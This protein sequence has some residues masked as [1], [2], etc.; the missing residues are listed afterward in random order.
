MQIKRFEAQSMTAALKMIKREFGPEAVILSAR[1]LKQE[2]GIF[3]FV[4]RPKVEVT[5]ATDRPPVVAPGAN[6]IERAYGFDQVKADEIH[7]KLPEKK[8]TS[9]GRVW[10]KSSASKYEICEVDIEE[11]V[12][13]KHAKELFQIHQQM[14]SQGIEESIVSDLLGEVNR[15]GVSKEFMESRAIRECLINVLERM[16]VSTEPIGVETGRQAIA[17]FVG[18]A[19]V[20]KTTTIA[21]IA[22]IHAVH[23]GRQVALITLDDYRI[24]AVEQ[25]KVYAKIIGIPAITASNNQ[26]L[27]RALRKLADYDLI[28]I[29]TAGMTKNDTFKINELK[30]CLDRISNLDTHLLL[31]AAIKEKDLVNTIERF[32]TIPINKLL[33][34]K[35]D[36]TGTCGVILNQVIQTKL[37]VSYFTN[38]QGVPEDIT[39]PNLNSLV[40]LILGDQKENKPWRA[41]QQAV[42]NMESEGGARQPHAEAPFVANRNTDVFHT[43]DCKWAKKIMEKNMIVFESV[44]HAFEKGYDPCRLCNPAGGEDYEPQYMDTESSYSAIY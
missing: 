16:G 32:Q 22:S 13:K 44:E 25:L 20:R 38:G 1:S 37:P 27:K 39:I 11:S 40:N 7:A 24:A 28:L 4:S 26:E 23:M 33:F 21:K 29:D 30:H 5:A 19:G 35:L 31:N 8:T 17:A 6:K 41:G 14:L 12:S 36:E 10:T 43:L 18:P 2:K 15:I 34:T 3:G 9:L 42:E